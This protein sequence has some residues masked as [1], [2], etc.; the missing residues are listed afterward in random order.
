MKAEKE[1]TQAEKRKY[2]KL[3]MNLIGISIN[4]KYA[5]VLVEV[6]EHVLLYKGNVNMK[7]IISIENQMEYEY[8]K[9]GSES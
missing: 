7:Q 3:S 5:A 4:D 1:M 9:K 6:Y 8:D 2:M